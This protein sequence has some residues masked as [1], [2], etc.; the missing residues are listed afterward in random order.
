[1][2]ITALTKEGAEVK[3]EETL[4]TLYPRIPIPNAP[5][6]TLQVVLEHDEGIRAE[7][8]LQG[9]SQL[10][11]LKKPDGRITAGTSSQISDG[12]SAMLICNERGYDQPCNIK[13]LFVL[14]VVTEWARMLNAFAL[15]S[16]VLRESVS[17]I[18]P[19]Y[20]KV[21]YVINVFTCSVLT[22]ALDSRSLDSIPAPALLRWL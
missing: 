12:A 6:V 7:T 2:P 21:T 19:S 17:L 3:S 20:L 1:M 8:T 10:G 5:S 22:D 4:G 14:S 13:I 18:F 16:C 9:L 11:A 15:L